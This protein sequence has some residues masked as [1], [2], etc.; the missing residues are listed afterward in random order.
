M[1]MRVALLGLGVAL[2][3]QG[4]EGVFNKPMMEES[5]NR[6]YFESYVKMAARLS[7]HTDDEGIML[8]G[9]APDGTPGLD[10][11]GVLWA[12]SGVE[13]SF[14]RNAQQTRYESAY[15]RNGR[16]SSEDLIASYG[17]HAAMSYGPWQIMFVNAYDALNGFVRPA[18]LTGITY[19]A[20]GATVMFLDNRVID[21]G[22]D[23]LEKIADA[24]NTGSH[25]DSI[26][27][28]ARYLRDV[29]T[30]YNE[31]C[32]ANPRKQK[33]TFRA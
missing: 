8:S 21:R 23:T 3:C 19:P 5:Y 28:S 25:R 17:D 22:A 7:R 13:T 1:R 15:G 4:P 31:W 26:R 20:M 12:L 9:T 2:A 6:F 24:W 33:Q 16:Y 14:G 27:P 11:N 30:Y 10:L 29:E 32:A 18:E